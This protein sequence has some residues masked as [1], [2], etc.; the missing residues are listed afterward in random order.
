M[1]LADSKSATKKSVHVPALV[2]NNNNN[3]KETQPHYSGKK[4]VNWPGTKID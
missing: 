1:Q 3:N 4:R 2:K